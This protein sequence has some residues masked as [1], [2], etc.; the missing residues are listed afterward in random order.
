MKPIT[1]TTAVR[2]TNKSAI[3]TGR[4]PTSTRRSSSDF[5]AAYVNRGG[6]YEVK[7]NYDRAL[8]D[9][10][11]AIKLDPDYPTAYQLRGIVYSN[12]HDYDRAI[13]DYDQMIKLNPNDATGYNLHSMTYRSKAGDIFSAI[14][15]SAIAR[16]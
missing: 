13:A 1:C 16:V 9:S 8:A 5:A 4:S 10:N 15:K 11:Q 7:G 6:I 14:S 12:R 2:P 3:V